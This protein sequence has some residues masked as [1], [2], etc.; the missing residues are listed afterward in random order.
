M[1]PFSLFTS[2]LIFQN[3][4]FI[5]FSVVPS[6]SLLPFTCTPS[7]NTYWYACFRVPRSWP[8]T[9]LSDLAFFPRTSRAPQPPLFLTPPPPQQHPYIQT[10][11]LTHLHHPCHYQYPK[12]GRFSQPHSSLMRRPRPS[13]NSPEPYPRPPGTSQTPKQHRPPPF[14]RARLS[15]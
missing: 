11:H 15:R 13:S 2:P 6:F 14:S 3:I 7:T 9:M 12:S 8:P 1:L 4:I 5:S 10:C